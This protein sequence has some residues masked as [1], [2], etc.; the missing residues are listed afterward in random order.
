[1]RS[2]IIFLTLLLFFPTLLLGKE[3]VYCVHGFL[4]KCSSMKGIGKAFQRRGYH[5]YLWDYPSRKKSIEEHA[6]D[7]AV[8]LKERARQNPNEPIHF[9][10][11]SLGGIILRAALNHPDCPE[12]AKKGRAVLLSPPNQGSCYGRFLNHFR[13]IRK[14]VG[15]KA[16]MQLLNSQNFEHLGQFP[17]SMDILVISGTCSWN[18]FIKGI[19]DGTVRVIE[20]CLTTPHKHITIFSGHC[21]MMFSDPVITNS[22]EFISS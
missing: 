6:V 11:H 14:L 19:N 21:W 17:I 3:S 1:M 18:P 13:P 8:E 20:G 2:C 22:L 16:G 12:E 10:T 7:L 9:V 15:K 4:R 5:A